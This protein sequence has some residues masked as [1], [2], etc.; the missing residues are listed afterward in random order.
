MFASLNRLQRRGIARERVIHCLRV[1]TGFRDEGIA[2]ERVIHCLHVRTGLRDDGIARERVIHC[3]H[4][5]EEGQASETR[6][7]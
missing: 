7:S 2:R 5:S 4:F 1:S 3:L 6:D